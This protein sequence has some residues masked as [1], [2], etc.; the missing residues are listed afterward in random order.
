MGGFTTRP[1]NNFLHRLNEKEFNEIKTNTIEI[2]LATDVSDHKA[3]V[4]D[5][6]A[7]EDE[8]ITWIQDKVKI[9]QSTEQLGRDLSGIMTMQRRLSGIERDLGAI[10]INH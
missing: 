1:E 8:T 5:F 2:V 7:K 4:E 6:K 10:Q 3:A 9:V